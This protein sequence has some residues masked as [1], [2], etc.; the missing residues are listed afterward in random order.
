MFTMYFLAIKI[1]LIGP[2][3]PLKLD[4]HQPNPQLVS[5]VQTLP[6][7][8]PYVSVLDNYRGSGLYMDKIEHPIPQYTST[9]RFISFS[10]S[11]KGA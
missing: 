11:N 4:Q 10:I 9:L 3:V 5:R 2:N 8:N 1:G 7:H 6:V